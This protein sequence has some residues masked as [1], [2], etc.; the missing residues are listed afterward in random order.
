MRSPQFLPRLRPCLRPLLLALPL[1][2]ALVCAHAGDTPLPTDP[3]KRLE[4]LQN[5]LVKAAMDGQTRVHTA[6]WVDNNGKLHENVR[7][8]SDMKVRGVRVLNYLQVEDGPSAAIIAEGKGVMPSEEVCRANLQRYRRE[9]TFDA[10]L[11]IPVSGADRHDWAMLLKQARG[12]LFA[13]AT[14]ARKWSLSPLTMLPANAYDRQLTGA[15]P[16]IAPYHMQLELL[17]PGALGIEPIRPPVNKP[18]MQKVAAAARELFNDDA[19]RKAPVPFVM[20]LSVTERSNQR[21]LWQETVPLFFPAAELSLTSQPLPPGLLSEL[22]RVLERWQDKMDADFGCRPQHFNVLPESAVNGWMI[23]GGL[24]A[25]LAIGDQLLLMNREHLPA[26]ILE[27]DSAQHL[28][29]VEVVS[30]EPGKALI[31]KLA[32]PRD[33]ARSGDWVATPF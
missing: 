29:L 19:P 33:I 26:R 18:V 24:T 32:G 9:A 17:P 21:L 15:K 8:N 2:G 16:D 13:R 31:R 3:R 10:S 5:A 30:V 27:P 1:A 20:R 11:H 7:I 6:A 14:A 28:A 22:D 23:N 4:A 12:K 25:G